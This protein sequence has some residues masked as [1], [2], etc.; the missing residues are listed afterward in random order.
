MSADA[1]ETEGEGERSGDED[2]ESE[3]KILPERTRCSMSAS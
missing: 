3:P 1:N 2:L